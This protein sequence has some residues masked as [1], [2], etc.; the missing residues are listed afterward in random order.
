MRRVLITGLSGF[1]GHY[2]ARE[3]ALYGWEVW[4]LGSQAQPSNPRYRPVDLLDSKAVSDWVAHVQPQ[5]VVHLAAIA[6]VAHD[7][8]RAVYDV[9]VVGSRNLLAALAALPL[10][11]ERVLLASSA[12][13]YGNGTPGALSENTPPNP[14]N[15]Y[16][17]SKLA[18]EFM[19][20]TWAGR[21][22]IVVTR[23]FNYSGV[24]QS[25]SFLL[26]KI[27]SHFQRKASVIELGN[28]DVWRDFSDVRDLVYAYRR[29]LEVDLSSVSGQV[30]NVCSERLTSLREVLEMAQRITGHAL[31]VKVNPAFVRANEVKELCGDA[32][33]LRELIVRWAPRPVEDTLDWMLGSE[34]GTR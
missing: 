2:L 24:G 26:P 13:V 5:A 8:V 34:Q 20:R 19:A 16:A 12:N 3:L 27:V 25:E 14:A 31:D 23:P 21:L 10:P 32:S 11:P 28:L 30:V 6:F 17:V 15:D 4:G 18:M 7:D 29:L 9:N 1:T 33:R 22:P